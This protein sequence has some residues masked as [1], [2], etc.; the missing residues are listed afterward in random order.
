M[1]TTGL[2]CQGQGRMKKYTLTGDRRKQI[3]RRSRMWDTSG[4]DSAL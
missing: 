3:K 4:E 2:L 1:K